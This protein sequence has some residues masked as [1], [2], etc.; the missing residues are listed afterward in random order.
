[1]RRVVAHASAAAIV[2]L[3]PVVAVLS[4]TPDF[5]GTW[6][7]DTSRSRVNAAAGL[8]G[9]IGAGA[10][11]TLHITHP[12]NGAVVVESELNESHAR[13][14]TP[15]GES[16]TLIYVG[17][18]GRITMTSRWEGSKLVSE[19]RRESASGTA[20]TVTEVKE[21]F[22]LSADGGT[23]EIE[24]TTRRADRQHASTLRYTRLEAVGPCESWPSPCKNPPHSTRR[25]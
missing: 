15:G 25:R 20:G 2:M 16:T 14:Y 24:V 9:L 6:R 13:L 7:L 3:V 1:M 19:G 5:S 18:A 12:A 4:Q 8:A 17:E 21:V 22:G 11:E 10:P 23:L